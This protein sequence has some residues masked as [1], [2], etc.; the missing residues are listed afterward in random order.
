M[1][2][3]FSF[4]ALKIS[5]NLYKKISSKQLI[6][7][8]LNSISHI[9]NLHVSFFRKINFTVLNLPHSHKNSIGHDG[10]NH[11]NENFTYPVQINL[12]CF[13]VLQLEYRIYELIETIIKF[14]V[15]L[16]LNFS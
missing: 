4:H 5:F 10:F 2:N 9:I 7:L 16:Q 3:V 15:T 14:A 12:C 11:S 8:S 13:T 6:A 1:N